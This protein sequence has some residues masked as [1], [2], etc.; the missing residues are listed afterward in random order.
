MSLIIEEFLGVVTTITSNEG[1]L[2]N[3]MS[4]V[5]FFEMVMIFDFLSRG[6]FNTG[7]NKG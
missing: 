1:F 4:F 3:K 7:N 2:M 5:H 6:I